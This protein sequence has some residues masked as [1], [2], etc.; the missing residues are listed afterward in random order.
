M[1]NQCGF[2]KGCETTDAIQSWK[3]IERKTSLS[4]W[5][6]S[7][8]RR[9]S[10]ASRTSS[11]LTSECTKDRPY[12]LFCSS[13]A[14][15]PSP[16]TFSRL[17]HGRS[18]SPMM[19]SWPKNNS[20]L[21]EEA[22]RWHNRRVRLALEHREDRVHGM[23]LANQWNHLHRRSGPEE[24]AAIQ[25]PLLRHLQ[26]WRVSSRRPCPCPC[27]LDEVAPGNWCH[28]QPPDAFVFDALKSK[29]YKTVIHAVALYASESCPATAKHEQ[30]LHV[31]EMRMLHW[32]LQ[33]TCHEWRLTTAGCC[34][35]H[36]QDDLGTAPM[37][38]TRYA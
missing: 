9:L 3:N 14:W 28:M 27:R 24:S 26:R 10:I 2:I 5:R 29:I 19:S 23:R 4:T 38:W 33:L 6:S 37:V 30:A 18:C 1:L 16:L 20:E 32:S 15:T 12:H 7:T 21:E 8:W 17:T 34:T 25:V 11:P 22:Q 13:S 35:N 31:M 36:G